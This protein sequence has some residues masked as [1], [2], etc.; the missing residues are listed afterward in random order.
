MPTNSTFGWPITNKSDMFKPT[1]I[2]AL[3]GAA[4]DTRVTLERARHE[5]RVSTTGS[6][7]SSGQFVGQAAWVNSRDRPY[8][9]NGSAWKAANGLETGTI[10]LSSVNWSASA[11]PLR[12]TGELNIALPSGRFSAAPNVITNAYSTDRVV[13]STVA[14]A[15]T[16]TSFRVRLICIAPGSTSVRVY[17]AAFD[18]N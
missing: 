2:S 18:S 13:W 14:R 12:W 6:L 16:T 15:T 17:W 1:A 10:V 4:F 3:E 11:A 8:Y 9:W 5:M 7:P